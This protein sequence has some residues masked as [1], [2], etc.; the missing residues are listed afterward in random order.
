M[1]LITLDS[2]F[3]NPPSSLT[4]ELPNEVETANVEVND[5]TVA[6]CFR[7]YPTSFLLLGQQSNDQ[8]KLEAL[9]SAKDLNGKDGTTSPCHSLDCSHDLAAVF[10][11]DSFSGHFGNI[12]ELTME[13]LDFSVD[14]RNESTWDDWVDFG[15]EL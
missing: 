2:H 14:G 8:P 5:S 12:F 1:G 11:T 4:S 3:Q 6:H 9:N 13:M 7:G 15:S 10:P